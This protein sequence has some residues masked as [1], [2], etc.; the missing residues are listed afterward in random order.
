MSRFIFMLTRNDVTVPDARR[1]FEEIADLPLGYVGFKDLGLP[2][3][4]LKALTRDIRGNGQKVMLEVVSVTRE[5]EARSIRAGVEI[6]VDFILGGTHA[7]DA[8]PILAGSGIGYMPFPGRVIGHP[9]KLR[10]EPRE[11]V[12][13]ARALAGR[14]GVSGLDLLAY[15]F[16][17]EVEPLIASILGAVDCPVVVAGSIASAERVRAVKR[18]GAWGFTVGSAVFDQTFEGEKS[19]RGQVSAILDAANGL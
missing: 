1:V 8:L 10:G 13:S 7:G 11:I 15:R 14:E 6:G 17:G 16:D 3:E 12:E 18:L 9:S 19:L 4:E 5:D 2:V